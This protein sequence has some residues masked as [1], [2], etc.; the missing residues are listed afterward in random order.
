MRDSAAARQHAAFAA[1][2]AHRWARSEKKSLRGE[3]VGEVL[4]GEL[5]GLRGVV[6]SGCGCR[7]AIQQ[8][9]VRVLELGFVTAHF[10]GVLVGLFTQAFLYR[11]PL[12]TISQA[13][14][15]A[16]R[17]HHS[18]I[19]IGPEVGSEL[20]LAAVLA[21]CAPYRWRRPTPAPCLPRHLAPGALLRCRG[22]CRPAGADWTR[23]RRRSLPPPPRRLVALRPPLGPPGGLRVLLRLRGRLPPR[24]RL[25]QRRRR[26]ERRLRALPWASCPRPRRGPAS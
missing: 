26:P 5:D 10:L 13:L 9:T 14:Y 19:A 25:R 18:V 8:I 6:G 22:A 2:E 17:K 4:G 12:L 23:E 20:S 24:V 21:E 7:L 16:A 15:E 11:R 3:V 1:Y